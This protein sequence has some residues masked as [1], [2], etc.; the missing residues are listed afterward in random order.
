MAPTQASSTRIERGRVTARG[1]GLRNGGILRYLSAA[2]LWRIACAARLH[3]HPA[4]D[5]D[6]AVRFDTS[7]LAGEL[8]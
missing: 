6:A 1:K 3:R 7:T 5:F 2:R 4:P 8:R